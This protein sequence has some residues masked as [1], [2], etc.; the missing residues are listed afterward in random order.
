MNGTG[1][2]VCP[3]CGA[4]LQTS[5]GRCSTCLLALGLD[6]PGEEE[7]APGEPERFRILRT[8]GEGGM[9][10]VYLA[11]QTEPVRRRV[12]LKVIKRGMDSREVLRRFDGERQALALMD[13]PCIARVFEAGETP[14]GQ[15]FFSMEYVDGTHITDHADEAKLSIRERLSLFRTLCDGVQHAHQKGIIHRDLKP[16]NIL[17]TGDGD[18][19]PKIIDFGIAKAMDHTPSADT[20]VTE[21]GVVLGT[22]QYMSPE[23]AEMSALGVDTRSD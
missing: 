2:H 5:D 19:V 8:L 7:A 1:P 10:T 22:P 6:E 12:A 14:S 11:E 13:H 3:E 21:L 23:Q 15:P 9:G 18:P 4:T 20:F 17:V 16:S